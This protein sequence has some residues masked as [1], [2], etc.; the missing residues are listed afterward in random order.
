MDERY[1]TLV[2]TTQHPLH[3]PTRDTELQAQTRHSRRRYLQSK[4]AASS[5]LPLPL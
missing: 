1:L 4:L 2:K 3:L 5:M